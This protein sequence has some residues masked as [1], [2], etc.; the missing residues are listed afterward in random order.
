MWVCV[1]V[2]GRVGGYPG[3]VMVDEEVFGFVG[4]PSRVAWL[5]GDGTGEAVAEGFE[6]LG[7]G[8]VFEAEAR[9]KLDQDGA[10]LFAKGVGFSGEGIESFGR[11]YQLLRCG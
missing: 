10:E 5:E 1:G 11:Y 2:A 7:C 6:E 4:K 9:W 3:D 8:A